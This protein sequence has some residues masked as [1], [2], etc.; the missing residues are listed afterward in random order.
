MSQRSPVTLGKLLC[1]HSPICEMGMII[2]VKTL[3]SVWSTIMAQNVCGILLAKLILEVPAT[4]PRLSLHRVFPTISQQVPEPCAPL[5]SPPLKP[6][7]RREMSCRS[8]L[9]NVNLS[10]GSHGFLKR[11]QELWTATLHPLPKDINEH[12]ES[13][14]REEES[15]SQR[16]WKHAVWATWAAII[17]RSYCLCCVHIPGPQR[18]AE[19]ITNWQLLLPQSWHPTG[20]EASLSQKERQYSCMWN[21]GQAGKVSCNKRS[22]ILLFIQ[23][24]HN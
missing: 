18:W 3:H 9:L 1:L 11:H 19:L 13:H 16:G 22:L 17:Y 10:H 7:L 15:A 2:H 21:H 24:I 8:F 20:A 6:V 23:R 5:S 4:D 14:L 12:K